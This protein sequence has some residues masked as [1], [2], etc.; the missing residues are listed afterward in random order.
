[1]DGL[2]TKA[3][4]SIIQGICHYGHGFHIDDMKRKTQ[5]SGVTYE[6]FSMCKSSAKDTRQHADIV[7]YFGVIKE[8]IMLDYHM[9]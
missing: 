3:Y 1:M 5:N 8:T 4:C 7:S 9:F 6:A 2:W